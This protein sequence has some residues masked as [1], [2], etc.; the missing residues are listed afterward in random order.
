MRSAVRCLF[1]AARPLAAAL[2]CAL[3]LGS[4]FIPERYEAEVRL[5]KD[6]SYGVTFIGVLTYAPLFG[7]IARKKISPEK[8]A[9]QIRKFKN[10]LEQDTYFKEVQSLGSGRFQV[11]YE[12]EGRFAGTDQMVNFP[13]R[14]Y[15]V[16]C[17]GTNL[18][19]E[20]TIAVSGGRGYLYADSFEEVGLS[21]QGLFRVSTTD[22]KVLDHNAQFIRQAPYPRFTMYDWRPRGFREVPP[23][24]VVKLAVDPRTGAPAL[25]AF[26]RT[27]VSIL[28]QVPNLRTNQICYALPNLGIGRA[29]QSH[30]ILGAWAVPLP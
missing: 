3:L 11:R 5:T 22:A 12:R 21:T 6:G 17:I 26:S 27:P 20:V 15:A 29:E 4:C 8:A 25:T 30:L 13:S 28:T 10:F 14:Q 2:L 16:F 19:G 18:R 24:I 9:E 7:Q 1:R 23:K